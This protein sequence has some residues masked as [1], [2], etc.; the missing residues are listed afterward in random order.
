[1]PDYKQ[2]K[3]EVHINRRGLAGTSTKPGIFLFKSGSLRNSETAVSASVPN[4][5]AITCSSNFNNRLTT[6]TT[7][8]SYAVIT[9]S[10]GSSKSN[11]KTN[12][13]LRY[14][15][16]SII[17]DANNPDEILGRRFE[18]DPLLLYTSSKYD[19]DKIVNIPIINNDDSYA[20]AMKTVQAINNES[21]LFNVICSASLVDDG[22]GINDLSPS[23]S[24][25]NMVIGQSFK[26]RNSASLQNG[27]EGKFLLHSIQSSSVIL[28][29]FSGTEVEVGT[30]Q[31]ATSF[32]VGG[33]NG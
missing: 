33:G 8:N 4:I 16:G 5:V 32:L 11:K 12:I 13:V 2:T 24:V 30:A 9:V 15:S 14:V 7:L 1:M 22:S 27:T 17:A 10:S 19:R 3:D 6:L 26:I 20:V 28:P 29:D 25:G 18:E 31:V 21:G 23:S